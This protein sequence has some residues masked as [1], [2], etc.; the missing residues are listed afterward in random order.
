MKKLLHLQLLP[1]LS[2]VQNF[3]LHL[4][5]GLPTEDYDIHVAARP[6]GALV[7]AVKSRGWRFIPLPAMVHPISPLDLIS[8]LHLI[9]IFRRERYDIVHT[10]S[11]KPGLLG[12]LAATLC[13]V[14]LIVHTSHGMPFQQGQNQLKYK[15]FIALEWLANRFCHKVVYVNHSDRLRCQKLML[16]PAA[17]ATTIYNALPKAITDRLSA[18]AKARTTANDDTITIGSTMRFS[19]Q[20][21][22]VNLISCAC[23]ACKEE[24]RLRF[25]II[26]D[27]EHLKLCRQIVR[28]HAL[29]SRILLPG[30]DAQVTDWLP[31]FDAFILY[32]RWE[33]QPFSIIEAMYSGLPVIGSDIPSIAELIDAR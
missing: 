8:F 21:N 7:D 22:A 32:S 5:D 1:L 23:H 18:I 17:K 31:R 33:A 30:W 24:P 28:S 4:L 13:R 20:K 29:N 25:V 14:P 26:G 9:L 11:S 2:G 12:R 3:S 19:T 15:L 6:G 10:N 16:V 27:G